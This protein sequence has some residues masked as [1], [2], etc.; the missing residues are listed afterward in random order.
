MKIG[1]WNV[2]GFNRPLKQNGVAHLIKNNQLCLLGILETKLA[3]TAIPKIINRLFPG[4][5]QANNFDAIAGGRILII[6][7]PAVIDLYP[8]DI[9]PQVIHCRVTNK[10]SQLSFYISFTYGLYTVVNRRSMWEKLLELG[11]PL[12]M[13]WIILGDFNCVKSPAEKQLG[14]PP[15]WYELKDFA[16][17]CLA[18]GLHD[19]QTTGCYYTWYSNSD[20]NPVWCKLD[21]VLL[22]NDWLEAGFH[23]TAHFNPPGCLSDHSPDHPDFIPTIERQW[24][25]NVEGTPQFRLCRKL[26]ALKSSL[27]AFNNLHYSHISVRAKEADLALQDAQTHLESNP[28]DV[29]VR[30]SLGD[31]RK[32]ATFLAEAER[33]FYFQKAKIHFLKQG[34][35]TPNSFMIWAVTPAEVKTAVFQ[36]SDNKAPGPDGYTSC[37]FKKAWNIVGD[38]VCS[39][40][41]D[42]F[43][44]GRMLRQLNHT[45]IALVPKSEHSPSVADYRPISCCNVIYKV[46]TKII[47][48]RLSPALMQL[49][50]SSQAAFVGGRNITDNI[51]LAQEMVRQYSRKRISPRCTINVDLRKAF[52]SVSW[53]FLSRVLHGYGFPPLF[54]SWIMECVSTTSFSVALNGS[55]HGH[56]PGKK[57]LRQGDPMSPALFLL[58]MEYFSR[59]IKRSTT[60]SDFN[61]HPKCEKLK[62]THLL[63]ADDLMLFS[64]GDLP[65]IRILMECLQ[66]FRDVSGLA[67][68]NAKSNIFTAGIQND[69]LDEALAMTDFARGHMPV[70]YLGI[71]LAA[72]RLSV[73]DYSPLVDQI[74]GCIR[75]WTAKSLSFAGR[76][77]LIRSV[78]QGVECFWLQ[79]FPLPM[80][81]IEKIHRLCRAFLWNSKRAPVAWEDICHP[82]EE[83]GLGVRH[84]QS[85]NVALLARVLWNI[86]CKADTLWVKWVNEVYLRGAS[87]WDWQPKKDDSPLLRRLA[88]IRDRIITDFGSTEA[89]IRHMTEWTDRKDL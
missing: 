68:N 76:L 87:L 34:T 11:Q 38:L 71:P 79:V 18:L 42:F 62:I 21:R 6:W 51:F 73:T 49:V 14:V 1:F 59:L 44:S 86:H 39:A 43:R 65:S 45:I 41:M 57:G 12:N 60:N 37:F 81:V 36:I 5:C 61:F 52:D 67:V 78:L 83:G 16:D 31:L 30:D 17:C 25:L 80:A 24:R 77:E 27:K 46:I 10:S 82:K 50:D 3:A 75:K 69:T 4:W 8:E 29:T 23:C 70:R 54:I 64:R 58:C 7:N 40:V 63:F 19:A 28:G 33:H 84:I 55:L 56:F 47:A 13:P 89:A 74:A 85:W 72:Q 22:N 32:K 20:S 15:T 2:R 26:K 66:E 35:E 88:E 53:T 9:S 48:D